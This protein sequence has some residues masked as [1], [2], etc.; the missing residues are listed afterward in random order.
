MGFSPHT[1]GCSVVLIRDWKIGTVF[2]AYAGMFPGH[3]TTRTA[4]C[5][6][7]RIR[8]DVP[9][10]DGINMKLT[11]FSPHTRGCS[12][13]PVS[14]LREARV[15]PAYAGMFLPV[16]DR[17]HRTASFPRIRGD[18][19]A[20]TDEHSQVVTFSPHT[21]GCSALR[22]DTNQD[23]RVFP[24]YAGMF[25]LLTLRACGGIGFPRIRGDV[26]I[27][28]Q[29]RFVIVVFSPHTRGCSADWV[30]AAVQLGVFPAYAGMFRVRE[31]H[32]H[33]AFRF[34]RIRGDVP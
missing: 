4:P 20:A 14:Q 7:P 10:P 15:F 31:I 30:T 18:V 29:E 17:E 23:S 3:P 32:A 5:R 25:R 6:F 26:P 33:H 2:P 9:L 27:E 24:A 16:H 11:A 12:V 19:P 22:I 34:P 1:R 8:G 13:S 21:R 28:K